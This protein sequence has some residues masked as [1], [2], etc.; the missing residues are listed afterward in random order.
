M[1]KD[2]YKTGPQPLFKIIAILVQPEIVIHPPMVDVSKLLGKLVNNLARCS[3]AF[4]R[5]M[6]NTCMENTTVNAQFRRRA[7]VG[8]PPNHSSPFP[9]TEPHWAIRTGGAGSRQAS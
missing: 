7:A 5:W 9:G 8:I 2:P 4:T 6:H 3:K 1:E